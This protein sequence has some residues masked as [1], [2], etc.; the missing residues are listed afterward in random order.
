MIFTKSVNLDK[1]FKIANR[2][3]PD[4]SMHTHTD[5]GDFLPNWEGSGT[6]ADWELSPL[7]KT[8]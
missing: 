7:C 6:P 2:V 5:S 3:D 4:L 1:M 8:A